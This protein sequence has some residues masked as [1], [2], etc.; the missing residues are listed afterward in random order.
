MAIK[1]LR[2][3]QDAETDVITDFEVTF[4]MIRTA[5]TFIVNNGAQIGYGGQLKAQASPLT[6]LG[7]S[8]PVESIGLSDGLSAMGV[9]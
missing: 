3:I 1:S 9:A 8:S 2:P 4:K 5:A 6:D 7:T